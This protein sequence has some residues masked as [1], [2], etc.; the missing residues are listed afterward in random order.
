[1]IVHCELTIVHSSVARFVCELHR[2]NRKVH[3]LQKQKMKTPAY[4]NKKTQMKLSSTA[5]PVTETGIAVFDSQGAG[6][7]ICCL[8]CISA[9]EFR[10]N[11][12]KLK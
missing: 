4:I 8:L 6:R 2:F 11:K 3:F 5:Y 12:R 10:S 1:M 7:F 9:T